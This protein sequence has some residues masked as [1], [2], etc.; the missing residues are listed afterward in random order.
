ML[1]ME[2]MYLI[3]LHVTWIIWGA[4]ND[5]VF[6]GAA[7]DGWTLFNRVLAISW[8]RFHER[9]GRELSIHF[10]RCR[11]SPVDCINML[12]KF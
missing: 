12:R 7:A 8:E 9:A 11:S 2:P 1:H 6:N 10:Y 4:R 5:I 3:W